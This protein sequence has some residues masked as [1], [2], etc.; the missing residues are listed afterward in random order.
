MLSLFTRGYFSS[1]SDRCYPAHITPVLKVDLTRIM[2]EMKLIDLEVI[3]SNRGRIPKTK[4]DWQTILP[5][6]KGRLFSDNFI[7]IGKKPDEKK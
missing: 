7:M 2:K 6:L 5:F 4:I 3:Y 1:F